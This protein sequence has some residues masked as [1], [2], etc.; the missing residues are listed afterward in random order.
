MRHC[1]KCRSFYDDE[2]LRFCLQDGVPLVDVNQSDE[3]WREGTDF[4]RD[5]QRRLVH[6]I[7]VERLKRTVSILITTVLVIMVV[8]VITMKTWI[9]LSEPDKKID[10]N[11]EQTI[12]LTTLP[13]PETA[14]S[15]TANSVTSSVT[16]RE[17]PNSPRCSDPAIQDKRKQEAEDRYAKDHKRYEKN[18]REGFE[19]SKTSFLESIREAIVK[20]CKTKNLNN[21]ACNESPNF[22]SILKEGLVGKPKFTVKKDCSVFVEVTYEWSFSRPDKIKLSFEIPQTKSFRF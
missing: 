20:A 21:Q 10:Q 22:P 8:S 3:L 9:Y 5:A 4:V 19:S 15:V 17:S 7:R 1:P 6:R 11:V 14:P 12:S 2:Q 16:T 13:S 18:W